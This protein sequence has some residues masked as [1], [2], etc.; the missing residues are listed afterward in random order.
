MYD[1]ALKSNLLKIV[2]KELIYGKE[3]FKK[4]YHSYA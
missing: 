3:I 2:P 1:I 4:D